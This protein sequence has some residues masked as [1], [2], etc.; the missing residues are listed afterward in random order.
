[1]SR[2]ALIADD[3]TG[4]NATGVLMA[5]K[6][7]RTATFLNVQELPQELDFDVIS[8]T[9]NSRGV[10]K[11]EAYTAVAQAA[12]FLREKGI[13]L[14]CKR[15]DSTLRG[16]LGAEIDA[17]LDNLSGNELAVAVA[18]FPA[19]RRVAVG[20]YLLVDSVPLEKTQ[21]AKDPK[22]P[23]DSS[24]I[25]EII[26]RQTKHSVGY[27]GL[28]DVLQ[29]QARIRQ[30]LHQA[31]G[32]GQRIVVI[33]AVTDDDI[34][35][36]ADAVF[37]AGIPV[38][39]VDPGPFS[40]EMAGKIAGAGKKQAENKLLYVIGSVTGVTRGQ[41]EKFQS[42]Y[43][44]LL[45]QVDPLTLLNPQ[46]LIAEAR[47]IE[48][49]VAENVDNYETLG[50]TTY[51]FETLD[52]SSLGQKLGISTDTVAQKIAGGLADIARRVLLNH[53]DQIK[54]L[55]TSGGDTTVE[56][57]K[58]LNSSGIELKDEVLPLAAYGL[59]IGGEFEGMP[60]VTKGGLIGSD[61]AMI[62]CVDYLLGQIQHR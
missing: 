24:Q 28:A 40:A 23:V 19:S 1:M 22:T 55:Y 29:G 17:I 51:G 7:L 39:T 30:L 52:L 21:V 42:K 60:I 31:Q 61:E 27:I 38:I 57:C 45:V 4:A 8:I 33:D 36:I 58:A 15:I 54:A 53:S 3:L 50:I 11:E 34:C 43:K 20:G 37:N 26:K 6:G 25:V 46:E 44:S 12:R 9:T 47:R 10:S 62:Q 49:K 18:S 41:L 14:F 56:L 59:I 32:A 5:K 16:N 48:A 35:L 2:I 13:S